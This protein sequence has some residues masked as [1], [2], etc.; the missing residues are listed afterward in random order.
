MSF[1]IDRIQKAARQVDQFL[2]KNSRRPSSNAVHDL[3]TS[4]RRLE[5]T[6]SILGL[7]S[8]P[9]IKRLLRE[10]AGVRKRAGKV[11][12]MDVLTADA[13]TV[14]QDGEQDCLVQLLEHLG[15]E[16]NRCAKKL[17]RL[18]E[19]SKSH[20]R[21]DL[22]R[23]A[24][25]VQ[26]I[27]KE[28][29]DHPADSAAIPAT[30]AKTMSL[31]SEL[32]EPPRLDRKNLHEYRLKV[33]ELRNVLQLSDDPDPELLEKLG[34]VKDA[35]GEWHDW[36]ELILIARDVLEHGTLCRLIKNLRITSNSKYE[37]ALMLTSRLR[38]R[39]GPFGRDA[40]TVTTVRG[41]QRGSPG[42]SAPDN[43]KPRGSSDRP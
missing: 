31:S 4:T 39:R 27:L 37:R 13:L 40:S 33:K 25:R 8:S 26:K 1:D 2:K 28:A 22:K 23:S 29:E 17:R 38:E 9:R 35:I 24:S 15:A 7:D 21:R 12:D 5:T 19:A 32:M 43:R 34:E 41:R 36:E 16:R 14:K 11:R 30:V 18:I 20:L 10:L 42:R 6:F 3:R